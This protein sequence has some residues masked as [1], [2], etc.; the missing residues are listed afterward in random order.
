[1]GRLGQDDSRFRCSVE[2][3]TPRV[4]QETELGKTDEL[5]AS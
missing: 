2:A 4:D 3:A 5:F 1:M